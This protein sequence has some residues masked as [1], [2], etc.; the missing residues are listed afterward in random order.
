M[1]HSNTDSGGNT[2]VWLLTASA[3]LDAAAPRWKKKNGDPFSLCVLHG[4]GENSAVIETA[5]TSLPLAQL[6]CFRGGFKACHKTSCIVN[7]AA[8]MADW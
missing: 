8:S 4:G 6:S 1:S 3:Q 7:S 5:N 2:G